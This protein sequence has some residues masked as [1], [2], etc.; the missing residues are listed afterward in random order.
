METPD[1]PAESTS[2]PRAKTIAALVFAIFG[3]L[4][5]LIV[6]FYE[7]RVRF[8]PIRTIEFLWPSSLIFLPDPARRFPIVLNTI[9]L[10][11]NALIYA[12]PGFL[13]G[14]LFDFFRSRKS[15]L[16]HG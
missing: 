16:P 4:A 10:A 11:L 9:S 15:T 5:P 6:V 1:A 7:H 14:A 8:L 3:A 13:L 2:F 12:I